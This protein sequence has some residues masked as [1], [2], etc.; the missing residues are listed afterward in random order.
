MT[1][2]SGVSSTPRPFDSIITV[3][4][5]LDHPLSL[6]RVMTVEDVARAWRVASDAI[7]KQPRC[8]PTQLRDLAAHPREVCSI[9][10][11]SDIRGRHLLRSKFESW[12]RMTQHKR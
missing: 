4:G 2:S 3:S 9:V 11:P 7:F 5:I 1:G 12:R 6:S 10:L 8:L